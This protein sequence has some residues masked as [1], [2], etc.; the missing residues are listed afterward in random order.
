MRSSIYSPAR[1]TTMMM[2]FIQITD[3]HVAR[4]PDPIEWL[5][6]REVLL[7]NEGK[8]SDPEVAP[9]LLYWSTLY[10]FKTLTRHHKDFEQYLDS[11]ENGTVRYSLE[12][13]N[14]ALSRQCKTR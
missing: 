14:K 9:H 8:P 7:D 2:L 11:L 4:T 1:P 12:Y 6:G 5:V 10:H 13:S 3:I